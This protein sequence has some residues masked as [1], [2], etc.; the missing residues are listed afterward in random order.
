MEVVIS[1]ELLKVF[2]DVR[3]LLEIWEWGIQAIGLQQLPLFF[4][5]QQGCKSWTLH[6]CRQSA[7]A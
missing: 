6:L 7:V 3:D 5:L 4:G 2:P 1:A